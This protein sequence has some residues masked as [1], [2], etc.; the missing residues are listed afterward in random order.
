MCIGFF[1]TLYLYRVL[2]YVYIYYLLMNKQTHNIVNIK[3][4]GAARALDS[5]FNNKGLYIYDKGETEDIRIKYCILTIGYTYYIY[6]YM[7]THIFK[8]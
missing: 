6:I 3:G 2:L 5:P 7:Y 1:Y 8:L 4:T